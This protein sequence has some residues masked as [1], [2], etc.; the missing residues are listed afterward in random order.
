MVVRHVDAR[1][2]GG[3]SQL[4]NQAHIMMLEDQK[5]PNASQRLLVQQSQGIIN[6]PKGK[7][8][9]VGYAR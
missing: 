7:I 8:D 1:S 3:N 6:C 4:L 5:T 2:A 9:E